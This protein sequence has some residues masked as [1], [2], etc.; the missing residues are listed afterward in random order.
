VRRRVVDVELPLVVREWEAGGPALVYWGG[1]NPAAPDG[2]HEA[3]PAWSERYGLR[4]LAVSP[5]GLGETPPVDADAYRP[6]ELA[7]LVVRLLDALEVE[8][9]LYVGA[10]WGGFVGCRVATLAPGR[11]QGLVLLD[12]G[13][14]D[15]EPVGTLG[16]WTAA[17]RGMDVDFPDVEAAGAAIWGM[18]REPP[19][20]TW[21]AIAESGV[22]VLL[23]AAGEQPAQFVRA[24]PHAEVRVVPGAGHDVLGEAP[25]YVVAAVGDWL[26]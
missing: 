17:A 14:R 15:I 9:V 12:G 2:L 18:A 24:V 25:E 8:R 11:L 19:S 21:A 5:P 10:S 20:E 23:L 22:P 3:G 1:L 13:H 6:S 26:R 4:V 7:G 16:D